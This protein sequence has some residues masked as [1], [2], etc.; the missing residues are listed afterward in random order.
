MAGPRPG[1]P[2]P[3]FRAVIPPDE[4]IGLGSFEGSPLVLVFLRHL[5]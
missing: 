4:E 3:D 5:A 1:D 2:A